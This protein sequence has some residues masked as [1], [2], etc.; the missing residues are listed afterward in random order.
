MSSRAR[1]EYRYEKLTW[2]EINDAVELEKVWRRPLRGAVE[3]HGHRSPARRRP[4]LPTRDRPRARGREV[5]DKLARQLPDHPLRL[6]RPRHGLPGHDQHRLRTLHAPGARRHQKPRLPRLQED[7]PVQRPRLELAEP[8]PGGPPHEPGDRRRVRA[9]LVVEPAD[10]G[11]GVPPAAR[12]ES[13]FPGGCSLTPASWRAIAL[14]LPSK[15][16]QRAHKDKIKSGTIS[17]NEEAEPVPVGSTCSLAGPASIISWTRSSYSDT[18]V[19]GDARAGDPEKGRE[20]YE[21]AVRQPFV[22]F[23][24]LVPRPPEGRAAGLLHRTPPTMPLPWGQR[25]F[26]AS[27]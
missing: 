23:V 16:R 21:E 10:R 8:R 26:G 5:A 17:F 20:A 1:E 7:H 14:S 4:R 18:G 2:P 22:R 25:P 13:Q 6:H 24:S 11:Q 12:R 3:Q 9:D 15:R 27:S 19:L